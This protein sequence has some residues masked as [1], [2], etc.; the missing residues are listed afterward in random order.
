MKSKSF[1]TTVIIIVILL[2][3]YWFFVYAIRKSPMI[4]ESPKSTY[5]LWANSLFEAYNKSPKKADRLYRNHTII[6]HGDINRLD[7]SNASVT[8]IFQYEKEAFGE[9]GVKCKI[10][11]K[12]NDKAKMIMSGSEVNIKG[13]CKGFDNSFVLID[14]CQLLK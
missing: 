12:Y 1:N 4:D 5:Q 7:T 10:L 14:S 3:V 11:D 6:L 2:I 13:V 9:E 8:L